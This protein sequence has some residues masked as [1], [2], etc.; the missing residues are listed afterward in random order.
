MIMIT[1]G[2]GF[3][4]GSLAKLLCEQGERVLLTIHKQKELA[5]FLEQY[6][7]KKLFVAPL[8]ITDLD[9]VEKTIKD[10][11]V[12]SIIHAA[13]SYEA[14]GNLYDAM[15]VN[16]LG[17]INILEASAR[18]GIGRI[19][20]ISTEAVYQG[21]KQKEPLK[22]ELLLSVESDRY[23]PG[24]KRA[25]ENIALLYAAKAGLNVALIRASRIYGPL[26]AGVRS[27]MHRIAQSAVDGTPCELPNIDEA[28]GH[29]N[30]YVKDCARGVIMIHTADKLKHR[31]YNLGMGKLTTFGEIRDAVLKVAPGAKIILGKD[32]GEI[33]ATKSALDINACLDI[34][35]I[36]EELGFGPEYDI[37]KGMAAYVT[38]L[39]DKIYL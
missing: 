1:G 31:I 9:A 33:T 23:V 21:I 17:T 13:S 39:K 12:K 7:D 25:E 38:W 26:F 4:G 36:R 5:P 6:R 2:M 35:R 37:D 8:D 14:K 16:V 18:T 34:G 20:A 30:I 22:E 28:E 11:S 29:D 19:S 15:R 24:T 3:L 32:L 10:H 27:P